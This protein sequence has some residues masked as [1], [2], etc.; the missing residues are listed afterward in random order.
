[1][2]EVEK[3][4]QEFNKIN[5]INKFLMWIGHIYIKIIWVKERNPII[6]SSR[7]TH[8]TGNWFINWNIKFIIKLTLRISFDFFI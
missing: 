1:M 8:I 6:F 5:R 3:L 4:F 2:S 7:I